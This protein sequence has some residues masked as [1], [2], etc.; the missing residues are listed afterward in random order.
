MA[1]VKDGKGTKIEWTTNNPTFSLDMV[2]IKTFGL[3]GGGKIDATH[4]LNTAYTTAWAKTLKDVTDIEF[5]AHFDTAK[6]TTAPIN[7]LDLIKITYGTTGKYHQIWGF[8]DEI[9]PGDAVVGDKVT[10]T[11]KI[12]VTN[13]NASDV[14]TGPAAGS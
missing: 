6:L 13:L 11:G 10:V 8:L 1:K 5:E 7:S 14:E 2:K 3:Q 12:C 9:V 4:L